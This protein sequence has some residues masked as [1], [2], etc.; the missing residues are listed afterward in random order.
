MGVLAGVGTLLTWIATYLVMAPMMVLLPIG[1]WKPKKVKKNESSRSEKF[2]DFIDRNKRGIIV[3]TILMAILDISLALK[4]A[5]NSD[6]L[7]YFDKKFP[8]SIAN[9]FMEEHVG[10]SMSIETVVDSGSPEGIKDPVFLAKVES[11]QTWLDQRPFVSKT[12]SIVDILK[13]T[14]KSLNGGDENHYRLPTK[15]KQV[16]EQL[17]L[18]SMG[19][20]QGMDISNQMT[21]GNDKMRVTAMVTIH[22]SQR[23]LKFAEEIENKAAE[24]GLSAKVNGKNYL[25]QTITGPI[26]KSFGKSLTWAIALISVLLIFGLGSVK[27]G[28][29]AMIPNTLP[30]VFGGGALF[31]LGKYLDIGTVIVAAITLGIA[32]DDTI[33]FL[34]HFKNALI[35]GKSPKEAI[36]E[37]FSQ[38]A[39]ALIVTTLVL[40]ASFGTFY[41]GTFVPNQNFGIMVAII[42]SFALI[43]DL[44]FLP[45][46]LLCLKREF[47]VEKEVYEISC[48][49]EKIKK[50]CT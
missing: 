11:L 9:D 39:I 37:I 23:I 19:L 13:D 25:W 7:E 20:P 8:V 18:Y 4:V 48:P 32:V 42:L 27:L 26:I 43:C 16:A 22:D 38:T 50:I 3:I 35:E 12:I 49:T 1:R 29:L 33:H 15:R 6:P 44:I 2:V 17:F 28:L 5:V 45:A 24:L 40:V 34:N 47:F 30:I 31:V 21:I 14:N 36:S 10:G 46:L 41:F